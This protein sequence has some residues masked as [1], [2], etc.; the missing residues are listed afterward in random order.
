MKQLANGKHLENYYF[1]KT[2]KLKMYDDNKSLLRQ[3][4]KTIHIRKNIFYSLFKDN[5]GLT[6]E[7]KS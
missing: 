3:I 1:W 7:F 2:F 4:L 6:F 5:C